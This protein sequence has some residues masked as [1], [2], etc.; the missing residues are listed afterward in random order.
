MKHEAAFTTKFRRWASEHVGTGA[1]E[2]KHTRGSN[3][4]YCAELKEHQIDALKAAKGKYGLAYKIPDEGL[5]Y[6]PFDMFVLKGSR[7]WVVIAYPK[8]FVVI[9]ID[10]FLCWKE[11]SLSYEQALGLSTFTRPLGAL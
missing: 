7:A 4:F 6:R 2:I 9:D 1:Y 5:A 10:K 8:A 3:S 11:P